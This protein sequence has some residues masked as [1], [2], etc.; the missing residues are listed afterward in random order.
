MQLFFFVFNW[1]EQTFFLKREVLLEM[2]MFFIV[3][4]YNQMYCFERKNW[5]HLTEKIV[6]SLFYF[7]W[8]TN[9]V[10]VNMFKTRKK[11]TKN[12]IDS[13]YYAMLLGQSVQWFIS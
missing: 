5:L 7:F 2:Y 3:V 1:I 4:T 12:D 10:F 8:E 13:C 6:L 9:A 11:S